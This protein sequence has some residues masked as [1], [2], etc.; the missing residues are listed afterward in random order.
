MN[1]GTFPVGA[2]CQ[3]FQRLGGAPVGASRKKK[4]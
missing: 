3:S 4:D 1:A 2:V